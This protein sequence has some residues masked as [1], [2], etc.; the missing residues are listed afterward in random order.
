[1]RSW[2]AP[3]TR[4]SQRH[5]FGIDISK[6]YA[7]GLPHLMMQRSHL[8]EIL[9]NLLPCA[10]YPRGPRSDRLAFALFERLCRDCG[11]RDSGRESAGVFVAV[12]GALL[13]HQ[14]EGDVWASPSSN[15]TWRCMAAPLRF[16]RSLVGEPAL[17]YNFLL[18]LF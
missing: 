11:D 17:R 14:A 10:G 6:E 1:M 5:Q 15:T 8:A 2:T 3:W 4:F 7:Q 9:V 16:I 12:L 18:V 13:Y